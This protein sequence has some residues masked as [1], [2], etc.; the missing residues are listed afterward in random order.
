MVSQQTITHHQTCFLVCQVVRAQMVPADGKYN[1][2][3]G[4][5]YA[6]YRSWTLQRYL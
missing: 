1:L 6:K 2:E 3:K 5:Y 4:V